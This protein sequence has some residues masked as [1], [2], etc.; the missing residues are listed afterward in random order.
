MSTDRLSATATLLPNG[1][2]LVTGGLAGVQ[3]GGTMGLASAEVYDPVANTWSVVASMASVRANHTATLLQNGQVLVVGGATEVGGYATASTELYDP[4]ANTWSSAGSLTST[5]VLHTATLLPNGKV[6]VTGGNIYAIGGVGPLATTEIYDPAA[7][8]WSVGASMISA[9]ENHIAALL[10]DGTVLVA[11]GY[12]LT[13]PVLA[14]AEIYDP[15]ADTWSATGGM[16][17]PRASADATLLSN[18]AVLVEGG[19][20]ITYCTGPSLVC[21]GVPYNLTPIASAELYWP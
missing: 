21:R 18:G 16:S 5:L 9:R 11:G 15:V 14:S 19:N 10:T 13:S 20:T 4:V 1:K 17:T 2:V 7:N 8:A 12:S 3:G 6:L